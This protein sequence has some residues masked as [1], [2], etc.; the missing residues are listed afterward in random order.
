MF[1]IEKAYHAGSIPI[2]EYVRLAEASMPH[3]IALAKLWAIEF[4]AA[5][6]RKCWR[7]TLGA[8]TAANAFVVENW[9]QPKAKRRNA[10]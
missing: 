10:Q 9:R 2:G 6:F 8:A 3:V 4:D 1:A 5:A 7:E